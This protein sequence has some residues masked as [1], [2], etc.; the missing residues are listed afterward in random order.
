MILIDQ[1]ENL[2]EV[3][4]EN[5][6]IDA[7]EEQQ[8]E[9]PSRFDSAL[10]ELD[11]L[12][13]LAEVK[14]EIR[15]MA[16]LMQMGIVRSRNGLKPLTISPHLTFS[17]NRGTGKKKVAQCVGKIYN[18]VGV[19]SKGH[20]MEASE[21]DLFSGNVDETIARTLEIC[22]LCVG[23]ILFLSDAFIFKEEN[24]EHI[25]AS[26]R[27]IA[28]FVKM[29]EKDIAVIMSG[30][31]IATQ[32]FTRTPL[33]TKLDF[34]NNFSFPD[35]SPTDL[36]DLLV[37]SLLKFDYQITDEALS[38]VG[39]LFQRNP[40]DCD[41]TNVHRVQDLVQTLASAHA[42]Y[43]Q[44]AQK[45]DLTSLS[46]ITADMVPAPSFVSGNRGIIAGYL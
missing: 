15:R 31:E 21:T 32:V 37:K 38:K 42:E 34:A 5:Q 1:I 25:E 44:L 12:V 24:R 2:F 27:V 14:T 8:I 26:M 3:P 41:S 43:I 4:D 6:P 45:T 22:N 46:V 39:L 20:V 10:E 17:G 35:C 33:A 18:E 36:K 16:Y 40:S 29:N 11:S 9:L 23:G 19:L 28:D 7:I 30:S 13:G